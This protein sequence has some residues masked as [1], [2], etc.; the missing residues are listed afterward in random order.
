MFGWL[1]DIDGWHT[2]TEFK[3][4]RGSSLFDIFLKNCY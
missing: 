4:T 3:L 1:F 2:S